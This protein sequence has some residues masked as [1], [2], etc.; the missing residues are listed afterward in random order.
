VLLHA[1]YRS[2]DAVNLKTV[3]LA[4]LTTATLEEVIGP[5]VAWHRAGPRHAASGLRVPSPARPVGRM[6]HQPNTHWFRPYMGR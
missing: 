6:T 1:P 4:N 3:E 5:G 2:A